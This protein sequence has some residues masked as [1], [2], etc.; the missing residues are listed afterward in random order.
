[1][2]KLSDHNKEEIKKLDTADVQ[3]DCG[4]EMRYVTDKKKR[5]EPNRVVETVICEKCSE[6]KQKYVFVR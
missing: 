4:G 2:K 6:I 5:S 1:M 3:C